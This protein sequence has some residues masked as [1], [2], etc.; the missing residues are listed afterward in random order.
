[1]RDI[2]EDLRRGQLEVKTVD[3][4]SARATERLGRQLR[5]SVLAAA[6]LGSGVALLINSSHPALAWSLV[7]GAGGWVAGHIA[8]DLL[9][10]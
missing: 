6:M 10:R 7:A 2:I 5:A 9:R 3:E 4:A 8:L 1:M